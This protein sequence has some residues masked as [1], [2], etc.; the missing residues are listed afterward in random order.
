MLTVKGSKGFFGSLTFGGYDS[1]RFEPNNVSLSMASDISRDLVVGLQSITST[2]TTN[3]TTQSDPLLS[4]PI[5]TFIDSTVPYIYLPED[6]CKSFA[7]VFGLSW[8]ETENIY[9]VDDAM[10]QNLLSTEANF[11]FTISDSKNPGPTVKI[12]L[13]YASFDLEMK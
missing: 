5:L 4:E 3:R 9:W 6:A 7:K 10:H 1:S 13:P 11:T 2:I 8:S 12:A